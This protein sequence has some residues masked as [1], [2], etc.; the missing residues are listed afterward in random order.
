MMLRISLCISLFIL[1]F[2]GESDVAS[3]QESGLSFLRIGTNASAGAMGDAQVST[4]E[5]AYATY[6]NPAGLAV[7]GPNTV[8]L[9]HHIWIADTRTYSLAGGFSTG[10][11]GGF[12]L[13]VTALDS[14][15]LEAREGP[16]DPAGVFDAQFISAGASYGRSF[17]PLR[18]GITAKYL[19]ESIFDNNAN[20]YAFDFGAQLDLLDESVK[21]GVA[22]QN[23]GEMS[24]LS[25]EATELPRSLRGGVTLFPFRVLAMADG[26]V[27]LNAFL[28]GEVSHVFPSETTRFHLGAA[29]EVVELVTV[30]LG[31]VTNDALRS[32]TVGGG[33]GSNGFT[34]D[35]AFLPFDGGFDGPGHVL[36][37]LYEW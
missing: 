1:L 13:F 31:Y 17:G 18:L 14:G 37:L 33:L 9:S 27:L 23:L 16:G 20:G 2:A 24:T 25:V 3:A 8:A 4:G 19:S 34:F 7:E 10:P 22:F 15:E 6:W 28:T 11:L 5:G 32:V 29:A 21:V 36:S 26:S 12:G 35:Y 30:R